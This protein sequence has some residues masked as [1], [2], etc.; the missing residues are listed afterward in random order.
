MTVAV[1]PGT[2]NGTLYANIVAANADTYF[3]PFKTSK[4]AIVLIS[5]LNLDI[6]CKRIY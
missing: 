6:G 4:F 2:L 3:L 1:G 5:W